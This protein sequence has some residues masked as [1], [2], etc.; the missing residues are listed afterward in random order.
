[1]PENSY[2]RRDLIRSALA[3]APLA[4]FDW[5][6]LPAKADT[7]HGDGFDAV[8]IGSGLGGL[9]CAVAFARK[10]YRPLVLE[11]HDKPGGYATAFSRPGGFVFDVSLHST[12]VG[13]RNGVRNLIGGLPEITDVEFVEHPYLYRAIFPD[14]DIR[15][16]QRDLGAY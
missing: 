7:R 3:A 13:E 15:V 4:A 16:K 14:H 11:Q 10:G 9:S 12:S 1:M 8:I 2:T 5:D 6:A